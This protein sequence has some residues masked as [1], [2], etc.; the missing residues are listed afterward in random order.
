MCVRR[1]HFKLW[2]IMTVV[3]VVAVI[4][5]T[6]QTWERWYYRQRAEYEQALKEHEA[7]LLEET[8]ARREKDDLIE[9]L[10]SALER[11]LRK[12]SRAQRNDGSADGG[13]APRKGAMDD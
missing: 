12:Q 7:R 3:G 4:L 13:P 10:R 2:Q 11:S 9:E 8:R 1:V 5:A 6:W